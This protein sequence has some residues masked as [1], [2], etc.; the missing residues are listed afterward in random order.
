MLERMEIT[1]MTKKNALLIAFAS[2]LALGAVT[3]S[4]AQEALRNDNNGSYY[5]YAPNA[6]SSSQ[7][8]SSDYVPGYG[9]TG[10]GSGPGG[11]W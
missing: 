5:R 1:M 9:N 6:N 7:Y 11:E 4:F 10:A 3:P 2:A 8:G